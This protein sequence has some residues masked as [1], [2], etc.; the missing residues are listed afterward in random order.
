MPQL[1]NAGPSRW[2]WSSVE[3]FA[4]C[5]RLYYLTRVVPARAGLPSP[6]GPAAPI[7]EPLIR[8]QIGHVG[9]AHEYARRWCVRHGQDPEA[10]YDRATAMRMAAQV[11]GDLGKTVLETVEPIVDGYFA[12]YDSLGEQLDVQAVEYEV[13]AVLA[14]GKDISQRLDLVV[15]DVNGQFWIYDHKLVNSPTDVDR[16]TLSGQFLLMHHFGRAYYREHFGGVRLN[17]LGTRADSDEEKLPPEKRYRRR[18]PEPAPAALASFPGFVIE[19]RR[20][21]AEREGLGREAYLPAFNEQVCV[22]AYGRCP[23]FTVCQWEWR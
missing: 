8:G 21:I 6:P 16:Y 4:R 23:C 9:L 3:A 18:S 7:S 20:R 14:D 1:I 15:R 10:Y 19:L 17:L 22:T 13:S 11:H 12:Y 5:E 2:G